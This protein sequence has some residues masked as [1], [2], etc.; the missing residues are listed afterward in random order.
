MDLPATGM[1]SIATMVSPSTMPARDA[2]MP[3]LIFSTM[4][5]PFSRPTM[6]PAMPPRAPWYW[7]NALSTHTSA[8]AAANTAIAMR[9]I[10]L[11]LPCYAKKAILDFTCRFPYLAANDTHK[12]AGGGTVFHRE[13]VGT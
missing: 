13:P 8:M 1:P 6:M 3:G 10:A 5:E 9:F 4:I 7:A 11:F 12:S 2:P